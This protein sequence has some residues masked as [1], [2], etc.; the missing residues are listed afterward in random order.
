MRSWPTWKTNMDSSS[1]ARILDQLALHTPLNDSHDQW[2]R[3][4]SPVLCSQWS[5]FCVVRRDD[6]DWT[7]W[8]PH[9][10]ADLETN[11]FPQPHH[12]SFTGWSFPHVPV[13][14]LVL[15]KSR[16]S[17]S[18]LVN[19]PSTMSW[20]TIIL[21]RPLLWSHSDVSESIC[22]TC[23]VRSVWC[24]V[25]LDT[26]LKHTKLPLSLVMNSVTSR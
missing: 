13:G 18:S 4:E 7:W 21:C 8:K 25:R 15:F 20:S 24:F 1:N 11:R 16:C 26:G 6:D 17:H 3:L 22:N 9:T 23:N 2:T 5:P 10:H 19:K 14:D 12:V